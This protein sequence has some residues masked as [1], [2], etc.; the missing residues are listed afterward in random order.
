M[1]PQERAQTQYE[2][3][4]NNLNQSFMPPSSKELEDDAHFLNVA[5]L[6]ALRSKD[7][8]TKVGT[9]IATVDGHSLSTGYNGFAK[10][11][12]ESEAKWT[13]PLKYK[14]VVHSEANALVSAARL[15]VSLDGAVAYCTLQPCSNCAAQLVNAGITRIVFLVDQVPNLSEEDLQISCENLS[16]L[17]VRTYRSKE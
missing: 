13:R 9:V 16:Y 14:Y 6:E 15:G 11:L 4:T 1:T 17:Q 7:P 5:K 3:V 2:W 8:S 12:R 10:G